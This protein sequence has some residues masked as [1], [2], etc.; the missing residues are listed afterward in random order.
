MSHYAILFRYL[1]YN[2]KREIS[3]FLFD[4]RNNFGFIIVNFPHLCSNI[5]TKP[6]NG[7]YISRIGR[8]CDSYKD[9]ADRHYKS[10][11]HLIQQEF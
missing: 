7:V 4:K 6:A 5:P 1:N 8:I 9:F 11:I 2:R 3:P 10:T